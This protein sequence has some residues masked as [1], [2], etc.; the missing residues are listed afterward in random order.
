MTLLKT[1][2]PSSTGGT[3]APVALRGDD[4]PAAPEHATRQVRAAAANDMYGFCSIETFLPGVGD[5]SAAHDD[6]QGFYNYVA[7]FETPNFWFEDGGVQSWIY[8]EDHDNWEDFYGFDACTVV[9]HSGHGTMDGNGV[10][11]MPI[12][13]AWPPPICQPR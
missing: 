5:L 6:A 1:A 12:C 8:G 13:Q 2:S 3:T 4:D 10:F 9:Y 7:Q 11:S